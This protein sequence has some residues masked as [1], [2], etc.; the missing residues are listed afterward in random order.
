[1]TEF[2]T[3]PSIVAPHGFFTR[4][5]G[6]SSGNFHSLNCGMS[7]G[8]DPGCVAENRRRAGQS[9][10]ID[11]A[12]LLGVKQ[13][14]GN[15]VVTVT[16]A[17]PYGHGPQADALV[18]D[19]A[20]LA[21]GIITADCAPVLF[22]D[23]TGTIVG[24][25]HAGWRGALAGVIEATAAAMRALGAQG[26]TAAIGPCIH[27]ESYEVQDDLRSAL[28]AADARNIRFFKDADERH[29]MFD[30]PGFIAE[31]LAGCGIA[32]KILPHDT[33]SD[34]THFFSHRRRTTRGEGPGGH[35]ISIIRT[36]A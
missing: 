35:Q 32:S 9:L 24:A 1:M 26:I 14:H 2:L 29:W 8:D 3:E 30:L 23:P 31:R 10:H 17:W 11:P 25:A 20:G 7:N 28:I 13:V 4:N 19:R 33:L 16:A 34:E 15:E 21:L 6:T 5:G 36:A 18:T 27:Q 12:G 22:A